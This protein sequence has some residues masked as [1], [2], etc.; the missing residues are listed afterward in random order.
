MARLIQKHVHEL[1]AMC[2]D[3]VITDEDHD[4]VGCMVRD[5]IAHLVSMSDAAW[6]KFIEIVNESRALQ[7]FPHEP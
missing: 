1:R 6:K 2:A 7:Q 5:N 4:R 3:D